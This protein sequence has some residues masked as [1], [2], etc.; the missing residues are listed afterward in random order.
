MV[1]LLEKALS[2]VVEQHLSLKF[3]LISVHS[4]WDAVFLS[5]LVGH[6]GTRIVIWVR[7][8]L[9]FEFTLFTKVIIKT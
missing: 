3:T 8:L 4:R 7:G 2:I 6:L 5:G 9:D 1:S